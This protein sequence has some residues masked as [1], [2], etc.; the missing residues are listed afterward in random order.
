[1]ALHAKYGFQKY[2][3]DRFLVSHNTNNFVLFFCINWKLLLY[4]YTINNN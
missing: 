2:L 4:Y 1:M 3:Y